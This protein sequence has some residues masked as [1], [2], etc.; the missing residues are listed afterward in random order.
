MKKKKVSRSIR[1]KIAFLIF[2]IPVAVTVFTIAAILWTSIENNDVIRKSASTLL[3]MQ[4]RQSGT[5]I[6][7]EYIPI[8]IA[9]GKE[10][11][12]PWTL[13]AAHHRI[14]TRFS[15]MNIDVSPAG[16][17]GPMQFMPCT[18]VGWGYPGCKELGKG[19]I[20]EKDKTD[21]AVIKKYGGYGVDA[22]GDGIADPFNIEDAIFSAANY[23]SKSGAADGQIEKAIFHYNHSETYVEDVLWFF[24]EFEEQRKANEMEIQAAK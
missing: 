2:L 11:G 16:A 10:Y 9:A 5:A 22:N 17:E 15:T 19:S 14:E 20:P 8:Y 23:L 6:P 1:I 24:N 13:L 4:D 12:I 21:P 3:S 18:F 7:E